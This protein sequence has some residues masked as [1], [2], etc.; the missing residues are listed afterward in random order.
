MG[1]QAMTAAARTSGSV[2]GGFK[3]IK[4]EP[5]DMIRLWRMA[6]SAMSPSTK[7]KSMGA[8]L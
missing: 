5:W 3:K 6:D 7:A 1:Q 2:I 4:S 8:M